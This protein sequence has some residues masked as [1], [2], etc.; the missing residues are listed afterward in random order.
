MLLVIFIYDFMLNS[1][2]DLIE[3]LK[4]ISG[5]KCLL[6]GDFMN[7][8][9]LNSFSKEL[10]T[11]QTIILELFILIFLIVCYYSQSCSIGEPTIKKGTVARTYKV[12]PAEVISYFSIL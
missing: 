4:T 1:I 11:V 7:E 12:Y 2:N 8:L 6:F 9:H 5:I 3:F 10:C